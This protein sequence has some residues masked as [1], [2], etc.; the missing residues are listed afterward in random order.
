M[1]RKKT[2]PVEKLVET[3][4]RR[5]R[6]LQMRLAGKSQSE[7]A[8][9]FGVSSSTV[10]RYITQAV[11][12]ITRENAEEYLALELSRL[13]AMWAGIWDD[14]THGDTWKI[15]RALAIIDQR[16]KLTGSY[17]TA[18]L[19]AVAEAKATVGDDATSMVSQLVEAL[20]TMHAIYEAED[21]AEPAPEGEDEGEPE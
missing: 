16:A 1:A 4:E 7:I 21:A 9:E 6:A 20:H 12:A 11:A 15:D 13:D 10:S 18:E 2:V 17:K 19:R 3:Q 14:A 8:A 5:D